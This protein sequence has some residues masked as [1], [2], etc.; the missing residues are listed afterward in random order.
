MSTNSDNQLVYISKSK[1]ENAGDGLFANKDIPKNMPVVIYYGEKITNEEICDVYIN[2]P[3]KYFELNSVIRGS[4]NNYAIKGDKKQTNPRFWGVYVNDCGSINNTNL[5]NFN[6][7]IIKK[8]VDSIK[9]C[10]LK[11]I[12]TLDYP[13]YVSTR[14]IK[15]GEELYVHYGIGYWL[16]HIGYSP[17]EIYDLNEKYNFDSFYDA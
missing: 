3:K 8:Y 2:D 16:S 5:N 4:S 11:T 15:K 17:E 14:N 12:E 13:V 7:N 10:N 9:K 6:P 1:I